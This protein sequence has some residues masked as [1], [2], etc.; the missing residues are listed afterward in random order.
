MK[1][2]KWWVSK[3]ITCKHSRTQ[4]KSN[5]TSLTRSLSSC[6]LSITLSLTQTVVLTSICFSQRGLRLRL[7]WSKG[8]VARTSKPIRTMCKAYTATE[9][10]LRVWTFRMSTAT[11]LGMQSNISDIHKGRQMYSI[12]RVKQATLIMQIQW[13][14]SKQFKVSKVRIYRVCSLHPSTAECR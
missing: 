7:S 12:K 6:I 2:S 1:S 8:S 9:F 4:D 5:L 11:T 3:G 14:S 10:L 13:L